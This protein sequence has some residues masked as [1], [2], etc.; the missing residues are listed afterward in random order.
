[1]L[2]QG[3]DRFQN[4]LSRFR[5]HSSDI[6]REL[7][8]GLESARA[9]VASKGLRF[10]F[11]P[12]AVFQLA[13]FLQATVLA[14]WYEIDSVASISFFADDGWCGIEE[15]EAFGVH[16]F[17][18]YAYVYK[19]LEAAMF[20]EYPYN[21][22]YPAA[23]FA[24]AAVGFLVARLFGDYTIGLLFYL[25][26][27]LVSLSCVWLTLVFP[28]K[29]LSNSEKFVALFSLGPLAL[30]AVIA[31]D[32]GNT[33]GFAVP[34]FLLI[35]LGV[36][37]NSFRLVSVGFILAALLKPHFVLLA[38]VFIFQRKW[39]ALII[40]MLTLAFLHALAY[41]LLAGEVLASLRK[42]FDAAT[43]FSETG[44]DLSPSP[45]VAIPALFS[46]LLR[47]FGAQ[48]NGLGEI[49]GLGLILFAVTLLVAAGPR[50]NLG[51]S[52]S[53]ALIVSSL[54]VPVVFA[55][56]L[57]FVPLVALLA[58]ELLAFQCDETE[59]K[60]KST[61]PRRNPPRGFD[62][63]FRLATYFSLTGFLL[64]FLPTGETTVDMTVR[65]SPLF[66]SLILAWIAARAAR[67]AFGGATLGR[68][69]SQQL[70]RGQGSV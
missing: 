63:T 50:V 31:F 11:L 3:R 37:A 54:A 22:G 12:V 36:F 4:L 60:S 42:T 47:I 1:M 7:Q 44:A 59:T 16:C 21:F 68:L 34:A 56:Y 14:T 8:G 17:G 69:P 32:R 53:V 40:S 6:Q 39:R 62:F 30:P 43:S 64:P 25:L 2:G 5:N 24:P 48:Q 58:K 18:D 28:N 9:T 35:T 61:A 67:V 57:T 45:N 26:V 10:L 55:Y 19:A 52:V 23:S 49:I 33:V 41:V 27:L 29:L 66:W 13:L 20:W 70:G 51:S 38:L 15:G 65:L 46:T